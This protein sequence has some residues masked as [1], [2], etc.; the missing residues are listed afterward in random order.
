AGHRLRGV[1]PGRTA[2]A[3]ASGR[4]ADGSWFDVDQASDAAAG[5]LVRQGGPQRLWDAVETAHTAWQRLGRPEPPRFTVVAE[6]DLDLQYI[7]HQAGNV[8]SRWPLPL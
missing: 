3:I 5:Y 4:S 7:R 8:E 6:A 2:D 1:L